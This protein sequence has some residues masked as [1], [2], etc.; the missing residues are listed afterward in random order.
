MRRAFVL[1]ALLWAVSGCSLG[2]VGGE[3]EC[4]VTEGEPALL[5][6]QRTEDPV[7]GPF[8]RRLSPDGTYWEYSAVEV[9]VVDGQ[10]VSRAVEPRWRAEEQLE[11]AEVEQLSTLVRDKFADLAE[12]YRP[13]GEVSDGFVVTWSACVDG[14]E[15]TVVLRSVDGSQVPGLAEI[16][17]AFENA[18]AQAAARAGDAARGD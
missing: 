2:N 14:E 9:S 6:E 11:P 10:I 15:R 8:I 12:E 7:S 17:A 5:L 4:A 18:V 16:G 13:P 1:V 3:E